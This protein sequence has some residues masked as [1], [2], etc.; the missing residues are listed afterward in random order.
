MP[1]GPAASIQGALGSGWSPCRREGLSER[2]LPDE[3][4]LYDPKTDKAYLLNRSAAAIWDLC[5]GE[6]SLPEL[7]AEL[8]GG[9]VSGEG[10]LQEVASAI[11]RLCAEG[12]LEP[13]GSVQGIPGRSIDLADFA[14]PGKEL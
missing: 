11:E 9:A 3:L 13:P 4:V 2:A 8:A 5:D 14:S 6:R 10:L 1:G 7:A 12:L